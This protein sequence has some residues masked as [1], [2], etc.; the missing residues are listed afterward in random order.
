MFVECRHILP[1]GTK[2]KVPTLRAGPALL[3]VSS[4]IASN[5]SLRKIH[6][7][8]YLRLSTAILPSISLLRRCYSSSSS[9]GRF[10]FARI[11][12]ATSCGT[13]S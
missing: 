9:T 8:E 3:Y 1:R 7:S 12:S 6:T 11:L 5:T 10:A 4:L 13:M 2:C